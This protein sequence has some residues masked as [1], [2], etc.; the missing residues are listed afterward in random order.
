MKT[1]NLADWEDILKEFERLAG[2]GY[3]FRGMDDSRWELKTSLERHTPAEMKASDAEIRL[4]HEFKRRAHTYLQP[5]H[6]PAEDNAG[7]W[8]ALM[9]HFGAPTRLLDVT[10]S[11]YVAVYFAIEEARQGVDACAVWA[12]N[13][14]WCLEAAGNAI[15]KDQPDKQKALVEAIARG[16]FPEGYTPGLLQG[17]ESSLLK[18]DKWLEKHTAAIVPFVPIRLS[19]R[20]SVQQGQF[21]VPRDVDLLFMQNLAALGDPGNAVI[22]YVIPTAKRGRILERL[23]MMNMTRAQLFPGLDGFAQSFRQLLLA[24]PREERLARI[25][26]QAI[27]DGLNGALQPPDGAAE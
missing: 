2:G 27:L 6:I 22:K 26:R 1:V 25:R 17:V 18:A 13:R 11:P 16:L 24:E 5:Q 3:L 9:Q 20:L 4:L 21:L 15:L 14:S 23:R 7:E 10:E 8:L 19:E 12:I